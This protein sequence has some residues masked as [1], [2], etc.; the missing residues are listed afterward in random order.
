[1]KKKFDIII[2]PHGRY[3]LLNDFV[4]SIRKKNKNK[5]LIAEDSGSYSKEQTI[6]LLD[7][8]NI[9]FF[10]MHFDCGIGAK[11][12]FLTKKVKSEYFLI[13]DEDHIL[14]NE[15]DILI[16]VLEEKSVDLVSGGIEGI[17]NDWVGYYSYNNKILKLNFLEKNTINEARFV[18][19]FYMTKTKTFQ[20]NKIKWDEKLH[21]FD[22]IDFFLRF[23]TNL[24]IFHYDEIKIIKEV[25]NN[26]EKKEK[27]YYEKCRLDR[28][29]K[30]KN[31]FLKKYAIKH[32]EYNY[33]I[34]K[35]KEF[36]CIKKI[37]KRPNMNT[38]L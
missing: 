19:N 2:A 32:I 22:H 38:F 14:L 10:K 37:T 18:P 12:N 5:I 29:K 31:I 23:P 6:E 34:K 1:M 30:Y 26:L 20:E 33:N 3:N 25:E 8:G 7:N 24:K 15:L 11:R 35:P 27:K 36:P 16:D 17:C 13:C 9:E 21:L 4:K 28:I